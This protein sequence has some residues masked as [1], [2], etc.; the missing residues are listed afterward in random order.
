MLVVDMCMIEYILDMIENGVDSLKIE[1][2]M[3]FIY[4]VFIVINCYKVVVDV[5]MES[6]E[7]FEVIKEDLIDEF[8][9]VV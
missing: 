3:K 8:W 7:V 1:G 9:K 4:Y 6:L 5:Y 2:C